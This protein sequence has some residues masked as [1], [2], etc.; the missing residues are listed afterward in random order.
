M[1]PETRAA[2]EKSIEQWK[3][4]LSIALLGKVPPLGQEYCALC[5]RFDSDFV[6]LSDACSL[7]TERCPV[8][9][10]TGSPGCMDSPYDDININGT[11][12][13]LVKGVKK[14]IEFL[15]SLLPKDE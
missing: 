3:T 11:Q 15:E 1:K 8:Y 9:V 13:E 10:K 14:E 5:K 4:K 2:L 12:E 7:G 6:D